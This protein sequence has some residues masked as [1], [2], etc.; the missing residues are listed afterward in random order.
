MH[1]ENR[2]GLLGRTRTRTL[3]NWRRSHSHIERR[4]AAHKCGACCAPIG[5]SGSCGAAAIAT[6]GWAELAADSDVVTC[7]FFFNPVNVGRNHFTGLITIAKNYSIQ[8][9]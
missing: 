2:V 7:D 5:V 8:V 6:N 1:V 4:P 3:H 9:K